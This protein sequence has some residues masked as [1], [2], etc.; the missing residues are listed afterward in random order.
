MS[1]GDVHFSETHRGNSGGE[2]QTYKSKRLATQFFMANAPPGKL[3][4]VMENCELLVD[5]AAVSDRFM[6]ETLEQAAEDRRQIVSVSSPGAAPYEASPKSALLCSAASFGKSQYLHPPTKSL[7]SVAARAS[8]L[9]VTSSAPAPSEAFPSTSEQHRAALERELESHVQRR[10]GQGSLLRARVAPETQ[11]LACVY[12]HER[13]DKT[14][15]P[16]LTAVISSLTENKNSSWAC[17]WSSEWR[18]FFSLSDSSSQVYIEGEMEL[19]AFLYEDSSIQASFTRSFRLP[20]A[21]PSSSSSSSTLKTARS[22]RRVL[23]VY[24][25]AFDW[26]QQSIQLKPQQLSVE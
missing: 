16:Q 6:Q 10:C 20:D 9:V 24:A 2:Q 1:Q 23:P 21:N 18:V 26:K 22:L 11:R 4:E 25:K 15:V 17:S 14:P 19:H 12:S 8:D 5:P 13:N 7:I 3:R